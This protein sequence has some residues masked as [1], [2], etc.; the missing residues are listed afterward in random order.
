MDFRANMR[1]PS[2]QGEFQPLQHGD[3]VRVVAAVV[4]RVQHHR[5]AG[6]PVQPQHIPQT[7]LPVSV[8]QR[9]ALAHLFRQQIG[10]TGKALQRGGQVRV[11][12]AHVNDNDT[13]HIQPHSVQQVCRRG[14][15]L[16]GAGHQRG[17]RVAQLHEKARMQG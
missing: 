12:A 6:L 15:F 5:N 13:G 3:L 16:A 11:R 10:C 2:G 1:G 14:Q 7:E 4:E 8:F 9:Q 17:V